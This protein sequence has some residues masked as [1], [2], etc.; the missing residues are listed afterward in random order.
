M[1]HTVRVIH[2]E[3]AQ[4]LANARDTLTKFTSQAWSRAQFWLHTKS[5]ECVR[6]GQSPSFLAG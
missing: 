3:S 1:R 4:W 6:L 2:L 5:P